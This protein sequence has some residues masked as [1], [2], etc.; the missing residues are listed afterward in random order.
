MGPILSSLTDEYEG[1]LGE[2]RKLHSDKQS[3][4]AV[5]QDPF[6]NIRQSEDFGIPGWLGAVIRANDKVSRLK[7]FARTGDLK[8]ESVE[9][10]LLDAANYFLI[11]LV[12]YRQSMKTTGRSSR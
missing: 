9:D 7:T 2:M 12:L 6:S 5:P 4:Y 11:G 8:C 10:S 3:D 1:V